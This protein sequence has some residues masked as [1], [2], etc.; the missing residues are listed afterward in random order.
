M[1]E[2]WT[3]KNQQSTGLPV[4]AGPKEIPNAKYREL[5]REVISWC[6]SMASAEDVQD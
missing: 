3:E 5:L 6:E 2:K 4:G 1:D